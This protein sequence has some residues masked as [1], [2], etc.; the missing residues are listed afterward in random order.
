MLPQSGLPKGVNETGVVSPERVVTTVKSFTHPSDT[1]PSRGKVTKFVKILMIQ[2]QR[3]L[4]ES[5]G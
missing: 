1:P 4:P 5:V 2:G 3:P